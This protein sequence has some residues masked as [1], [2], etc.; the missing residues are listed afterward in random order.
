MEDNETIS[1]FH[2]K[3][4]SHS[5]ECFALGEG[6]SETKLVRK[7]LR[8]LLERFDY[9]VAAINEARDLENMTANELIGSL[10]T[11]E[12]D[13]H[14]K[15]EGMKK[16]K[17][18]QQDQTDEEW[19]AQDMADCIAFISKKFGKKFTKRSFG[20]VAIRTS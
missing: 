18:S 19:D 20:E 14:N 4:Q 7:I 3:L 17:E 8:S 5:N 12:M 16:S 13:I 11:F 15:K 9:K 1:M 6:I 2:S 10:M